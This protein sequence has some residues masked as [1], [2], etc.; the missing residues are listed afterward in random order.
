MSSLLE[1][2]H[3]QASPSGVEPPNHASLILIS[4]FLL[5]YAISSTRGIKAYYGFEYVGEFLQAVDLVA[6]TML[7]ILFFGTC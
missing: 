2:L 1:T 3:L 5:A 7:P 6:P 4:N